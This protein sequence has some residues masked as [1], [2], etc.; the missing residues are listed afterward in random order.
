MI[1]PRHERYERLLRIREKEQAHA[2]ER[3]VACDARVEKTMETLDLETR[4]RSARDFMSSL[5]EKPAPQELN[6]KQKK[7]FLEEFTFLQDRLRPIKHE[8]FQAWL[9]KELETPNSWLQRASQNWADLTQRANKA[10]KALKTFHGK[11]LHGLLKDHRIH[12]GLFE[13][14]E[15]VEKELQSF[16]EPPGVPSKE[17]FSAFLLSI[18]QDQVKN[19]GILKR[20]FGT[21]LKKEFEQ[22]LVQNL[23]ESW[24]FAKNSH[25]VSN[26]DS[27]FGTTDDMFESRG[28]Q[29]GSLK[30]KYLKPPNIPL[31]S[32]GLTK[33]QVKEVAASLHIF[34]AALDGEPKTLQARG[35]SIK[36]KDVQKLRENPDASSLH[37]TAV[38]AL[39]PL[40]GNALLLQNLALDSEEVRSLG[41]AGLFKPEKQEVHIAP[42]IRGDAFASTLAHEVGHALRLEETLPLDEA[43]QFN[44]ALDVSIEEER[45]T[46]HY[47]ARAK[48]YYEQMFA[49]NNLEVI[50]QM[51]PCFK[52]SGVFK[53]NQAKQEE[54]IAMAT[55]QEEWAE[56]FGFS[57]VSELTHIASPFK[58]ELVRR[59][60]AKFG[61]DLDAAKAL[62]QAKQREAIAAQAPLA[63]PK[64]NSIGALQ[65]LVVHGV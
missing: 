13:R 40:L 7:A 47:S 61:F 41:A 19:P 56:M 12:P 59:Y 52:D 1:D 29:V 5:Q 3:I 14:V 54:M 60:T 8:A 34:H 62:M 16:A 6:E 32:E 46:S 23:D 21:T 30:P 27:H 10:K 58:E 49:Q 24:R 57:F 44:V 45:F 35:T 64:I 37:K 17:V 65:Q 55:L 48:E 11:E 42:N 4:F 2:N 22:V 43:F 63:L 33:E 25:G 15:A 20:V 28:S 31:R 36:F 53:D 26:M 50:T 9:Q 38:E 51:H 18:A 39:T